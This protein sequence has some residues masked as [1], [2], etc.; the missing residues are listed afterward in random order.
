[1]NKIYRISDWQVWV[2]ICEDLFLG[3]KTN[4]WDTDEVGRDLG[5]GDSETAVFVGE[6]PEREE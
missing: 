6:R 3:N 5:G 2:E 4:P 1:M